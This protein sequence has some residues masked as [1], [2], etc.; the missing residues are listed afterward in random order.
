MASTVKQELVKVGR[1]GR[2][3]GLRGELKVSLEEAY[4]EDVVQRDSLL[5]S[6]GSQHVPYFVEA[7][8]SGGNLVKFEE[9]DDKEGARLLQ[10]RELYVYADQLSVPVEEPDADHPF[11]TYVG[12]VIEDEDLGPIGTIRAIM[13]LPDHY[14]AEVEYEGREIMIPLHADLIERANETDRVLTMNLPEG[15]LGL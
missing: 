7:W 14:L 8:R 1:I 13:D 10:Q 2:P 3:H 4:F 11:L 9:V 15:L 6:V 5:V 12:Y